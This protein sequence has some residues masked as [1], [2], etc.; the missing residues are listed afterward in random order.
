MSEFGKYPYDLADNSLVKGRVVASIKGGKT[1]I[2]NC[3]PVDG[4]TLRLPPNTV[5]LTA[6]Q[7][8]TN[9]KVCWSDP[10]DT[11]RLE[12]RITLHWSKD[13]KAVG[14]TNLAFYSENKDVTKVVGNCMNMALFE[15]YTSFLAEV[16][17]GCGTKRATITVKRTFCPTCSH[18]KAGDGEHPHSF[19]IIDKIREKLEEKIEEK[20]GRRTCKVPPIV[21]FN[22]SQKDNKVTISWAASRYQD[23]EYEVVWD[24]G[25]F[26]EKEPRSTLGKAR[27]NSFT[28]EMLRPLMTY[29]FSVRATNR[30][31]TGLWAEAVA[32]T[33]N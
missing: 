24:E 27:S 12:N 31:G 1:H 33:V 20:T 22:V 21:A 19:E 10:F 8:N 15:G 18:T 14:S 2:K 32:E 25:S 11:A 6:T 3:G 4:F 30:C 17:N 29:R 13:E 26:W 7:W 28:T 9:A 5:T 16:T 23:V